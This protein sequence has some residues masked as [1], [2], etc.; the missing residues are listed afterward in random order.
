MLPKAELRIRQKSK[1]NNFNKTF[2]KHVLIYLMRFTIM[3]AYVF[4]VALYRSK[5]QLM[6]NIILF[7]VTSINIL[8]QKN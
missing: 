4:S 1:I 2:T 3:G 5:L 8:K 6:H 7:T